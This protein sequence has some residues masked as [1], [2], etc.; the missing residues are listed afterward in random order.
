MKIWMKFPLIVFALLSV[1]LSSC[2]AATDIL[3]PVSNTIASG[4][5]DLLDG[6]Y[7][8]NSTSVMWGIQQARAGAAGTSILQSAANPAQ[9]IF[10]WTIPKVGVGFFG[11]DLTSRSA[12]D[13]SVQIARGGQLASAKS[14]SDLI[15]FLKGSGW[16]VV[17]GSAI[18]AEIRAAV[19]EG[20]I[21]SVIASLA[22]RAGSA[23][24]SP[25][26]FVLPAGIQDPLRMI[27]PTWE[28]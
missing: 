4:G 10:T 2:A 16:T 11:I 18:P 3:P 8:I 20:L 23:L 14:V 28:Q 21:P 17:N 24:T 22:T 5:V 1:T 13:V 19:D 7:Y 27:Y 6:V 26:I 15:N 12:I 25:L 9:F